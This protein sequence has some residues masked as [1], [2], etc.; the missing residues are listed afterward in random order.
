MLALL[1]RVV[2]VRCINV[3]L[4]Y[5][6]LKVQ[7]RTVRDARQPLGRSA[8]ERSSEAGPLRLASKLKF[9]QLDTEVSR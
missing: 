4:S 9:L 6:N 3:Y 5:S 8:G 2:V 1:V 7:Y